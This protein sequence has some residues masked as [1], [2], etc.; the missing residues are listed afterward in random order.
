AYASGSPMLL[1]YNTNGLAHHDPLEA[2]ALL[3]EIGYQSVALTIDHGL[4]NPLEQTWRQQLVKIHRALESR[5]MGSVIETGARFLLD[6]R[7]KHEP[8]LVSAEPDARRRRIAFLK[9]AIDVAAELNSDCVSLWSGVVKDA[10]AD[11]IVWER[12]TSGLRDVLDHAAS[13]NVV[14]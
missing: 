2:I 13:K 11:D 3:H 14:I 8:T 12:L 10:A 9:Y 7:H 4:L 1:G 5:G 6:F